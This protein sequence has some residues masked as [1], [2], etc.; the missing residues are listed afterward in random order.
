VTRSDQA[1]Q[2]RAY[3]RKLLEEKEPEL[4]AVFKIV[5]RELTAAMRIPCD[6][7]RSGA[8]NAARLKVL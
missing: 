7:A 6:P 4:A 8:T 1:R 5:E 3:V 2:N